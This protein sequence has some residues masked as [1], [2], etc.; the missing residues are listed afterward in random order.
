MKP[1][2]AEVEADMFG[3]HLSKGVMKAIIEFCWEMTGW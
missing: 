2:D 3:E 1:N